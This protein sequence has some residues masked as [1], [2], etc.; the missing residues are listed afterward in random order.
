MTYDNWRISIHDP[1]WLMT[2]RSVVI[3]QYYI[4]FHRDHYHHAHCI[5]HFLFIYEGKQKFALR[6]VSHA[7]RF[8]VDWLLCCSELDPPF[9]V[10]ILT[11]RDLFLHFTGSWHILVH[12]WIE[13]LWG[14]NDWKMTEI[15]SS[16]L[17][18]WSRLFLSQRELPVKFCGACLPRLLKLKSNEFSWI[19]GHIIFKHRARL[20]ILITQLRKMS[21]AFLRENKNHKVRRLHTP[22]E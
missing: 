15:V 13:S 6:L 20:Y 5:Q 18:L 2:E 10:A 1:S 12:K 14:E 4:Q 8:Q 16:S 3:V 7:V 11:V 21:L 17:H 19:L 22:E 9:H